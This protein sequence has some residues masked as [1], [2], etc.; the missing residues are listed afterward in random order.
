MNEDT[1]I[2]AKDELKIAFQSHDFFEPQPLRPPGFENEG[3]GDVFLLRQIL[4]DWGDREC[5]MILRHLASVLEKSGPNSRL[6]IMDTVLPPPGVVSR[7]EE[8]LMRVRD[9][10]MQQAHNAHERSRLEWEQLLAKA[11]AG[12]SVQ[13]IVQPFKSL[14][15]IIEITFCTQKDAASS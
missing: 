11:H 3:K 1:P 7:T 2:L 6:L 15:A 5:V 9:L 13:Q 8:A 10:T 14:M 12:L 4:H